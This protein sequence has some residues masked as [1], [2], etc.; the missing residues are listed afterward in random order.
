MVFARCGPLY[1]GAMTLP[2]GLQID[3]ESAIIEE[4]FITAGGPG[5]QNVNKVAT[6]C[7]LRCGG[8]TSDSQ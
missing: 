8:R 6:A 4:K 1:V 3:L 2:S 7:Q 5:G